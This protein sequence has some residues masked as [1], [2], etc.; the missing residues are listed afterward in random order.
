VYGGVY[1]TTSCLSKNAT[2]SRFTDMGD[3]Q[4]P[5]G[6]HHKVFETE[7]KAIDSC[8]AENE[9]AESI[10]DRNILDSK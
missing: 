1:R 6:F 9:A 3:P 8:D 7:E 4:H 2:E 5:T 10:D